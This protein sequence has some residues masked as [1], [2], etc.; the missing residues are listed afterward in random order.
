MKYS[1]IV[2]D[3]DGV[4]IINN[5]VFSLKYQRENSLDLNE[6]QGFYH[7][8]FQDCLVGKADLKEELSPYLSKWKWIGTVDEYL[9][10]WFVT[11][12]NIDNR[13][14]DLIKSLRRQ[15]IKC[16]LATN[17][18]RYRT[19]YMKENMGFAKLF[20]K[21][22]SSSD[23]G[24]KKP[25]QKFYEFVDNN[26]GLNKGGKCNT[27]FIDDSLS[28]VEGAKKFGWDTYLYRDFEMLTEYLLSL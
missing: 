11:E 9:R 3:A 16:Y 12:D 4:L 23:I 27:L 14:V 2:F 20:D 21:V 6:V 17:Q 24:C 25:D 26:I 7:G 8:V 10:L 1:H 13:V 18:E 15:G 28:H 19:E 22:F 5:E